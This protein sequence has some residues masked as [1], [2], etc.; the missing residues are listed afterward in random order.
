MSSISQQQFCE[1]YYNED[2]ES[3]LKFKKERIEYNLKNKKYYCKLCNYNGCYPSHLKN[4]KLTKKHEKNT[5][6]K[7]LELMS[8]E[9]ININK[10]NNTIVHN[11]NRCNNLLY[12]KSP[13]TCYQCYAIVCRKCDYF[14]KGSKRFYCDSHQ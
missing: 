4:H 13:T 3:F 12:K 9:D 5:Q 10:L 11:C 6:L 8:L 1:N 7:E 2:K 14:C